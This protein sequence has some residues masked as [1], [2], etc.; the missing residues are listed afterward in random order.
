MTG[1]EAFSELAALAASDVDICRRVSEFLDQQP[2]I[3]TL[4]I[5]DGAT[6]AAG[7]AVYRDEPTEALLA[8]L[9]ACRAMHRKADL[10]TDRTAHA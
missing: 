7:H 6:M 9:A 2:V 10:V 4:K 5:D 8:C 1:N 3:A